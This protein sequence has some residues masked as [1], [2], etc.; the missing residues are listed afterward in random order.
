MAPSW[1]ATQAMAPGSAS[2]QRGTATTS[3]SGRWNLGSRICPRFRWESPAVLKKD[4][5]ILLNL[6]EGHVQ[7][8][9]QHMHAH[10]MKQQL[11]QQLC[12][13]GMKGIDRPLASDGCSL[14]VSTAYTARASIDHTSHACIPRAH[15]DCKCTL[16]RPGCN[17]THSRTHGWVSK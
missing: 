4:S 14:P 12:M 11:Y 10:L 1:D 13:R 9:R 6:L 8:M 17:L 2:W 3:M 5:G 7:C 15:V 16:A